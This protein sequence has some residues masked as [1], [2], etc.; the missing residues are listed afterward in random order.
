MKNKIILESKSYYG[1]SLFKSWMPGRNKKRK[2]KSDLSSKKSTKENA[3]LIKQ[4][5]RID[6]R[7]FNIAWFTYRKQFSPSFYKQLTNDSGWG[8]M[9]RSGQMM[10][11]TVLLRLT[12]LP[13]FRIIGSFCFSIKYY[14]I[15]ILL[16]FLFS[17]IF[18]FLLLKF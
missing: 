17:I 12:N 9:I 7:C 5:L 10:L 14:I 2:S 4:N 18:K 11:F 6:H 15:Y 8:C 1:F 16:K 3:L 13:L